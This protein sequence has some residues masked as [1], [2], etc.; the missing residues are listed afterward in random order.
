MIDYDEVYKEHF[1]KLPD[2][3]LMYNLCVYNNQYANDYI[4]Y[5]TTGL[6]SGDTVN[7]F[8]VETASGYSTSVKNANQENIDNG[9]ES[10]LKGGSGELYQKAG[11]ADR[12]SKKVG[13]A[14]VDGSQGTLNVYHNMYKP[15]PSADPAEWAEW[16]NHKKNEAESNT[17]I[18]TTIAGLYENPIIHPHSEL[19]N[20]SKMND[21]LD[22]N[23]ALYEIKVW[24]Q[25]GS[26]VDTTKDPILQ[27]TRG[28]GKSD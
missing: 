17:S 3:Y 27:G 21:A 25:E 9:G 22:A 16:N 8:V 20:L 7:V 13:M 5:D 10:W 26:T 19:P 18:A 28:G 2:I 15:S 14:L 6:S 1:E 11:S 4:T 23:R 24:M 12:D